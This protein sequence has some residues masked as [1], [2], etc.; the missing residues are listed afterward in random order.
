MRF[1]EIAVDVV[2]RQMGED[3][4]ETNKVRDAAVA[5]NGHSARFLEMPVGSLA[6]FFRILEQ[7]RNDIAAEVAQIWKRREL[8][9]EAAAAAADI[10]HKV[11]VL[12]PARTEQIIFELA[13]GEELTANGATQRGVRVEPA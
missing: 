13:D 2:L 7:S 1:A 3:G 4:K 12:Q 10:H 8:A 5:R 6:K 9:R 11:V